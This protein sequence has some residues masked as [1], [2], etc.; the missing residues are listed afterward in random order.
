MNAVR[1]LVLVA[2]L[3]ACEAIGL[4]S[5]CG[6]VGDGE[7]YMPLDGTWQGKWV[8]NETFQP[9]WT[10]ELEEVERVEVR[11][12]FKGDW[13]YH[14]GN[15]RR[16]D[17]I[18]GDFHGDYCWPDIGFSFAFQAPNAQGAINYRCEFDGVTN[19][20]DYF[21]GLTVC[22]Y[23][24]IPRFYAAPTYFERVCGPYNCDD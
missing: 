17:T 4:D 18:R 21:A 3:S 2:V 7:P 11:G 24:E 8:V 20:I 5:S 9:N 13:A 22:D 10:L 16:P 23:E 15:Y 6:G 14:I 1:S 19:D 12:R